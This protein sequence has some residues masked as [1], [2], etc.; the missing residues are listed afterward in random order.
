[1]I[2]TILMR[3]KEEKRREKVI[4]RY[5]TRGVDLRK[6]AAKRW[7]RSKMIMEKPGRR[8]RVVAELSL[9]SPQGRE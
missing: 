4:E 8:K 1:M 3:Q 6:M 5:V 9:V 7:F 2:L